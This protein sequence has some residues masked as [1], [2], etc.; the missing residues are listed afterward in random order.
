MD[1]HQQN[2]WGTGT[3]AKTMRLMADVIS[4]RSPTTIRSPPSQPDNKGEQGAWASDGDG[5]VMDVKVYTI[6]TSHLKPGEDQARKR[7]RRVKLMTEGTAT[8]HLPGRTSA[9]HPQPRPLPIRD[10]SS[11]PRLSRRFPNPYP[12]EPPHSLSQSPPVGGRHWARPRSEVSVD[13][14]MLGEDVLIRRPEE[15]RRVDT[16]IGFGSGIQQVRVVV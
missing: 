1:Y 2:R 13:R 11:L 9:T 12:P 10:G 5:D 8:A 7:A 16:M 15:I 4:R 3:D 6:R 14:V